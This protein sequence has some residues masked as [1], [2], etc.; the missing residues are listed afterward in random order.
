LSIKQSV[1]NRDRVAVPVVEAV[2]VVVA[3]SEEIVVVIVS[4]K[5]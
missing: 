1:G 3:V 2:A 4:G 5:T